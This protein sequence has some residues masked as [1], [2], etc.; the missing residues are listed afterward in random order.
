[1]LLDPHQPVATRGVEDLV[2][3]LQQLRVRRAVEGVRLEERYGLPEDLLDH[4]RLVTD[5]DRAQPRPSDDDELGDLEQDDH[6]AA[7]H[8]VPDDDTAKDDDQPDDN[9]HGT[10]DPPG[11]AVAVFLFSR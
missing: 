2:K 6:I 10:T 8:G 3:D 11:G 1:M 7:V 9:G 5:H 4:R